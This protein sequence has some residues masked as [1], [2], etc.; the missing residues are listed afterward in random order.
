MQG[1]CWCLQKKKASGNL[2]LEAPLDA[3][4]FIAI[5]ELPITA[6]A[7]FGGYTVE[8]VVERS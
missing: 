4:L 8:V 5:I 3:G 2:P 1:Y 6:S 7:L